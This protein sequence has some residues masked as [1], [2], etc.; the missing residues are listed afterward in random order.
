MA[1][2]HCSGRGF[3]IVG[4]IMTRRQVE[5]LL[6]IGLGGFIGAN[7][8]YMVSTWAVGQ[9]GSAFPWGTLIINFSGSC[10]LGVFIA[11]TMAHAPV[12]PRVRLFIAVGF[13]GAYTTFSTYANESV[14]LLQNGDWL[15]ALSNIL[16]TNLVCILGAAV[17]L[18]VGSRL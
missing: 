4:K 7:L 18:A 5:N 3:F 14:T 6:I 15:G 11:W 1:S 16:G 17:G 10:L 9:F 2:T 12:D 8:R 13:F